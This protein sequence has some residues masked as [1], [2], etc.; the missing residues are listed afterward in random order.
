MCL[1]ASILLCI[2]PCA[3][4]L[5]TDTIEYCEL[6]FND[7]PMLESRREVGSEQSV[8]LIWI[9]LLIVACLPYLCSNELSAL[10]CEHKNEKHTLVKLGGIKDH[11]CDELT[12]Y[13]YMQRRCGSCVCVYRRCIFCLFSNMTTHL[14]ASYFSCVIS[15]VSLPQS[16]SYTGGFEKPS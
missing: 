12:F 3:R 1:L 7:F 10:Q 2:L 5:C 6:L 4:Y 16:F 13:L 11:C 14:P 15:A 9:S 8:L